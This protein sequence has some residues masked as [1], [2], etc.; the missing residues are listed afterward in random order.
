MRARGD[1]PLRGL[2]PQTAQPASDQIACIW[3]NQRGVVDNG[4]LRGAQTG[5]IPLPLAIGDL[6]F[7]GSG[8]LQDFRQ[9]VLCARSP[10]HCPIQVDQATPQFTMLQRNHPA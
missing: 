8:R 7:P 6:L 2:Q 3:P 1:Q 9:Q 4:R 10:S 5:D